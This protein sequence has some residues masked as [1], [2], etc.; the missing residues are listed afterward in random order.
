MDNQPSADIPVVEWPG[1]DGLWT[2]D[3]A[4]HVA[5]AVDDACRQCGYFFLNR[6]GVS[7][8]LVAATFKETRHFYSLSVD[9]KAQIQL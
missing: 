3:E 9:E 7:A 2:K 6:H 4:R 8:D 1:R 5:S